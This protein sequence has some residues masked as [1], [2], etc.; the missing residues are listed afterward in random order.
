MTTTY[1]NA[2]VGSVMLYC[3]CGIVVKSN[4][5]GRIENFFVA[6][7]SLGLLM[8]TLSL[9][10]QGMDS[11]ATLG[12]AD[13]TYAY[14]W[15]D[16]A[17]LPSECK[18]TQRAHCVRCSSTLQSLAQVKASCNPIVQRSAHTRHTRTNTHTTHTHK[19]TDHEV[20]DPA[21]RSGCQ[22]SHNLTAC[23]RVHAR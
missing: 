19:V 7:R 22:H 21:D 10:A 5:R 15:W 4:I 12:S 16:G 3:A 1:G 13:L 17:V 6:G 9:V 23:N 14:H 8:T 20:F 18:W 11:N 2:V